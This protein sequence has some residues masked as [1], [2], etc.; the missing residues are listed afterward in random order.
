MP[1]EPG[2]LI[3]HS[4]HCRLEPAQ[5][6]Y[7]EGLPLAFFLV[8][9]AILAFFALV[10]AVFALAL[11]AAFSRSRSRAFTPGLDFL[12]G[13][14]PASRVPLKTFF[15]LSSAKTLPRSSSLRRAGDRLEGAL[16]ASPSRLMFSV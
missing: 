9:P 4:G 11:A 13:L 8:L 7:S 10:L 1:R 16:G 2:K 12:T 15:G 6:A 5:W 3:K 14:S